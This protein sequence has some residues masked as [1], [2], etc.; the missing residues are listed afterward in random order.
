MKIE[1]LERLQE[2]QIW[3]E[4]DLEDIRLIIPLLF[5]DAERK[6]L[7][8]LAR[9]TTTGYN[10]GSSLREELRRMCSIGLLQR[11]G[12]HK[13]AELRG[14]AKGVDLSEYVELTELGK[15][16][17]RRLTELNAAAVDAPEAT[18]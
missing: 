11:R 4:N 7:G 8:N 18:K 15:R 5:G 14:D 2:R 17:A 12:E 16:W 1:L 9:A 13:I 10:G 3:Q 6:H